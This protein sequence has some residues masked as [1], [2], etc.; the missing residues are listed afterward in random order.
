MIQYNTE[1]ILIYKG[2][3]YL[4]LIATNTQKG[5]EILDTSFQT[6][7]DGCLIVYITT[8]YVG[9][10]T[11]TI[12]ELTYKDDLL[13]TWKLITSREEHTIFSRETLNDYLTKA[14]LNKLH[15]S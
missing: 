9:G 8:S 6:N 10:L 4:D 1:R 15:V 11:N 5:G 13:I 2:M 7:T 12:D 14:K 3:H